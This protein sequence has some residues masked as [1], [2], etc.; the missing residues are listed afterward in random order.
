[1]TPKPQIIV[2]TTLGLLVLFSG[3]CTIFALVVTAAQVWQEHVQE[4][5]PEVTA[6][7]DSCGLEQ[8]STGEDRYYILCEMSYAVGFERTVTTIHSK[9]APSREFGSTRANRLRRLNDGS[10]L[11]PLARHCVALQPRQT[12]RSGIRGFG[13]RRPSH[14][15]QYQAARILRGKLR[16]PAGD[17]A[18]HEGAA[19][20]R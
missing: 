13:G 1:M 17:S 5:G 6:H 2:R 19:S 8:T 20:D 7:V 15:G 14:A 10:R 11:I 9:N 4:R 16:S 18:V 3:L 12:Q